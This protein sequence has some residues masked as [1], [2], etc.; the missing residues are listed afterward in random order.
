MTATDDA[1]AL[2]ALR[3]DC[4]CYAAS[5][6][7]RDAAAVPDYVRMLEAGINVVTVSSA[8]LVFPPASTPAPRD[9]LDGGARRA[10]PRSTPRAS[11]PASPATSSC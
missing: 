9:R 2:L 8:G 5:G 10:A 4:V 11:S 6:P 3:P 7:E 1:D